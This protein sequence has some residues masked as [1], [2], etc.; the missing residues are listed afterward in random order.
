MSFNFFL[1]QDLTQDHTLLSFNRDQFLSPFLQCH[2]HFWRGRAI[3]FVEVASMLALIVSSWLQSSSLLIRIGLFIFAR[4]STSVLL[5]PSQSI[6]S[7]GLWCWFFSL[8]V[9]KEL[10]SENPAVQWL[11]LPLPM[12]GGT[13]SIPLATQCGQNPPLKPKLPSGSFHCKVSFLSFVIN[14]IFT[15]WEYTI[16]LGFSRETKPAGWAS[17]RLC[18]LT[19]TEREP[20][21]KEL[22]SCRACQ[23]HTLQGSPEAEISL[24]LG[25]SV[26]FS[27]CLLLVG[28]SPPT[29]W[30]IICFAQS[31]LI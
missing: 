5:D 16:V 30:K 21:F 15:L 3:C 7:G 23:V 29:L 9:I 20:D 31:L 6:T 11:R 18:L 2:W 26:F 1:V 17:E 25:T 12:D 10:P 4:I 24:P 27:S 14:S 28:W 22:L 19:H 8:L 13:G